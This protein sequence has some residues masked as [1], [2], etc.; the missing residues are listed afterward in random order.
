[1]TTVG[2]ILAR[3]GS[4]RVPRKNMRTV[5]GQTLVERAIRS[6]AGLDRVYVSTD[7]DEIAQE[8]E[9]HGATVHRR[10]AIW[11]RDTTTSEDA[12]AD[13]WHALD[14]DAQPDVVVLLQ[15]TSPLRE[16]V[17]VDEAVQLLERT[18]A[19]SVVSVVVD[20]LHHFA[21]R[22]RPREDG[23][24]WMPF[25]PWEHRPRTQDLR[26]MG[27]ENGAI[28]AWTRKHWKYVGRRD[29]GDCRAYVMR[30]IDSVDIDHEEDFALA[31]ACLAARSA[32]SGR[33]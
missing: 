9:W 33:A 10:H 16:R 1:M 3:G 4:K 21:G 24:E 31:E 32:V 17:H 25:R 7:D 12:I 6:G 13:W 27:T 30:A 15:P 18:R 14:L 29:G 8:A 23:A 5:G 22:L 11:A 19:D 28:F 2:I 20:P 26:H